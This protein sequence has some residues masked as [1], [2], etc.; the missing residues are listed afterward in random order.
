[1]SILTENQLATFLPALAGVPLWT[2][3][4]GVAMDRYDITSPERIAAFLAQVAHESCEFRRLAENLNYSAKGLMDTWPKRFPTLD[5]ANAYAR[6]PEK[7]ANYV[8]ANRMGNGD[9]QSGDGWRFRGRGLL[10]ITGR[11]NY[12]SSQDALGLPLEERPE[13]LEEPAPAAL[14]AGFYWKSH[15]LNAL[16]DDRSD[17]NDGA[18][19]VSI[20]KK[21][22][23][24]TNG[25]K[26]RK[27]YWARA[28]AA[29]G[30]PSG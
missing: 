5:K 25:L 16:A 1:M 21:I 29:L 12:R 14:A 13:L 28:K 15:G 18:D 4:L 17:D 19:F 7:I 23:G 9:Q 6:Q 2:T 22:N 30:L 8:Y 11:E 24:G 20:T 10:Q 27:Q 3:T 26:S